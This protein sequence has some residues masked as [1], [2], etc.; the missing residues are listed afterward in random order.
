MRPGG[1]GRAG[2]PGGAGAQGWAAG[3][4]G[5]RGAPLLL[6][7]LWAGGAALRAGSLLL[8]L[9]WAG[10]AA[11]RARKLLQPIL[12]RA[13]SCTLLSPRCPALLCALCVLCLSRDPLLDIAMELEKI[14]VNDEYF[15]KVSRLS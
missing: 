10:G 14:A 9:L 6:P 3:R 2:G 5:G 4:A 7:L 13:A 15:V 8:S 11:L 1:L 12:A